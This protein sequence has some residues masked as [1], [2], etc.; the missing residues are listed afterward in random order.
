MKR[1]FIR[2]KED[3]TCV[4]CGERVEG[5]GYTNHCPKCLW[6]KH[7]D[8]LPGDRKSKCSS[9]MEPIAVSYEGYE[10]Y[11]MH[12]CTACNKIKR[13]RASPKDN[14]DALYSLVLS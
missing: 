1:N 12:R 11:I 7:V 9:P 2:N 13:N 4:N 8:I 6:S 14:K 5:N 3:F 10:F